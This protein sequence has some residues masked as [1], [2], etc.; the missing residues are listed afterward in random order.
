MSHKNIAFIGAG[1]MAKAIIHGLLSHQ[2]PEDKIYIANRS[3]EKLKEFS[4]HTSTNNCEM[5]EKAD[6]IILAVKP[7]QIAEVCRQLQTLCHK[8]KPIIVSVAA[9]ITVQSIADNLMYDGPI[10]RAMPNTPVS[11]G[12]GVTG[13]FANTQCNDDDKQFVDNIFSATGITS[14]VHDENLLNVI[15]VVAG[16]GPAYFYLIM[17]YLLDSAEKLGLDKITA[18][19]LITQTLIGSGKLAQQE[20]NQYH[21]LRN[22]VTSPKGSTLE[23]IKVFEKENLKQTIQ[24]ALTAALNRAIEMGKQ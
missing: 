24:T 18:A 11:I 20:N 4:T 6:I 8:N 1:N 22:A 17:E 23:A 12:Y 5:A 2:Y 10:I 3:A 21:Q 16:S 15:G 14:W 9:G 7:D 13:L 19:P